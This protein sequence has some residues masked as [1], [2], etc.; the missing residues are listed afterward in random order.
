MVV[1]GNSEA[2]T[3]EIVT[4][5]NVVETPVEEKPSSPAEALRVKIDYP[6]FQTTAILEF[7]P[8]FPVVPTSQVPSFT[9]KDDPPNDT[10]VQQPID[11][12]KPKLKAK[13]K[14][15]MYRRRPVRPHKPEPPKPLAEKGLRPALSKLFETYGAEFTKDKRP[16]LQYPTLEKTAKSRIDDIDLTFLR[17]EFRQAFMQ[18]CEKQ[19]PGNEI[20]VSSIDEYFVRH[21]ETV[22]EFTKF[23]YDPTKEAS[24]E[25]HRLSKEAGWIKGDLNWDVNNWETSLKRFDELWADKHARMERSMFKHACFIEFDQVYTFLLILMMSYSDI[26]FSIRL[27]LNGVYLS[28]LMKRFPRCEFGKLLIIIVS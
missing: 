7:E 21:D 16:Y 5:E 8:D 19:W 27:M 14:P 26:S 4:E 2:E 17:A 6:S 24:Q 10:P 25:F 18:D 13:S 22:G 15:R 23:R 1:N 12:P 3:P 28:T 9:L 11:T 20:M